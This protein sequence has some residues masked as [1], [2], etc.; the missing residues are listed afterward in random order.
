MVAGTHLIFGLYAT[1]GLAALFALKFN[2]FVGLF[3]ALGAVLP[4]VDVATSWVGRAAPPLS[5]FL[6]R[7]F[8]H[9]TFTHSLLGWAIAGLVFL[10]IFFWRREVYGGFL[11]GYVSHIILDCV[12]KTGVGIFF[13]LE[14]RGVVPG[15][16]DLRIQVRSTAEFILMGIFLTLLAVNVYIYSV[17]GVTKYLHRLFGIPK[18]AV[19]DYLDWAPEYR[20]FAKVNLVDVK[21]NQRFRGTVPVIGNLGT[22]I[23]LVRIEDVTYAV[24][25]GL[26]SN[27]YSRRVVCYRGSP[28]TILTQIIK[29]DDRMLGEVEDYIDPK[30]ENYLFGTLALRESVYVPKM[31][32]AYETIKARGRKLELDFATLEEVKRYRL[33]MVPVWSGTIKIRT[34]LPHGASTIEAIRDG[35]SPAQLKGIKKERAKLITYTVKDLK[36]VFVSEGQEIRRGSHIA[37]TNVDAK[38]KLAQADLDELLEQKKSLGAGYFSATAD[39]L[40]SL[41][42]KIRKKEEEIQQLETKRYIASISDGRI[43]RI[44]QAVLDNVVSVKIEVIT[45]GVRG[46][47][48]PSVEEKEVEVNELSPEILERL[49][50]D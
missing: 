44:T 14:V 37:E 17:G 5:K 8:G 31:V 50:E 26:L 19:V 34:I 1:L 7:R 22:S 13:P 40:H 16:D 20:V 11:I 3:T 49:E 35:L 4:D 12:N 48:P 47:L 32:N 9:R 27:W 21:T 36:E 42:S 28:V 41:N 45:S 46:P 18:T 43:S 33:M 6:E 39:Q 25:T 30:Q 2:V 24:G 15:R 23:L 29:M 10:P 38:I